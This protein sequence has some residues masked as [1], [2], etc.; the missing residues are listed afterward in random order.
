MNAL[1][2]PTGREAIKAWNRQ[3]IIDATVDVINQYGIAG[4]TI[5]RVVE[6]AEVSMGLVNVHFKSKDALLAQVLQQMAQAYKLHWRDRL[7]TAAL[8]PVT[9][10][11]AMVLADFDASVLNL[12]T[13]GVWFAFR[14][15]VRAR[16]EY[17]ELVGTREPEQ[18]QLTVSLFRK[19]NR[20]T[21]QKHDPAILT[22]L[23]AAMVEGMWTEFHLYPREFDR[24]KALQGIFLFLGS[25]YPD[26]FPSP[27]SRTSQG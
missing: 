8:D 26:C 18:V 20:K 24:S 17:L 15:Q 11:Q 1:P 22:R 25:M 6:R 19:L 5:A 10:L 23:L 7:E 12:K 27:D 2:R 21:G 16:P 4:T 3:K 9:Q 13:L 14:A